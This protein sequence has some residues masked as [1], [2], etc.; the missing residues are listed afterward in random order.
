MNESLETLE[1]RRRKLYRQLEEL[2]D[3]RPGMIS[4][5]YR[6][7]GKKNCACA[8]PHH[9]GHGPQYLWNSTFGGRSAAENLPLG[10][11]LEKVR[12]EVAAY[13]SFLR[14]TKELVVLNRRI[15]QLRPTEEI[16]DERALEQLKKNCDGGSPGSGARN[17][18]SGRQDSE[19]L[20]ARRPTR[21]GGV[22]DGC[23]GGNAQGR[24]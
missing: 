1:D 14:L 3:F 7:C 24:R 6:K 23:P 20:S 15:C 22:R 8:R 12:K 11:R 10:P 5:N 18:T 9:Q 4:V 13:Q 16:K 19:R 17:R 21:S 2:G